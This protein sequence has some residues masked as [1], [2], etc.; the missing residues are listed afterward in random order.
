[1]VDAV[2]SPPAG[3]VSV[4]L[5]IDGD[6][7]DTH[8]IGGET[9]DIGP[10]AGLEARDAG[11][12]P[13]GRLELR[14]PAAADAPDQRYVVQVSEDGGARWRTVGVG[15]LEPAVTL[16]PADYPGTTSTSGCWPPPPPTPPR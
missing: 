7:V 9:S 13:D 1:M 11:P 2:L 6:V 8:P 12:G 16:N 3:A 4:Q 5:L 15:L 14:W 10:R